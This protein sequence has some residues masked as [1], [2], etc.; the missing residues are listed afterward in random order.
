MFVTVGEGEVA[1]LVAA[2]DLDGPRR[3]MRIPRVD[4]VRV[5]HHRMLVVMEVVPAAD[6]RHT[7]ERHRERHDD[8]AGQ[9]VTVDRPCQQDTEERGEREDGLTA[10]G[11]EQARPVIHNV[12]D[13]P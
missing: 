7:G 4:G 10:S 9:G 3:V 6:Q 11:P 12:I 8:G 1:V 2:D 13:T 5:L